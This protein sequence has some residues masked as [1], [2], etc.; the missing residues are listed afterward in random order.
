MTATVALMRLE[1][2]TYTA[3][4]YVH[5]NPS[6]VKD[7]MYSGPAVLGIFFSFHSIHF[8]CFSCVLGSLLS[9]FKSTPLSNNCYFS[10][11]KFKIGR[12]TFRACTS[13]A[14]GA[15]CVMLLCD[16]ILGIYLWDGKK[17]SKTIK[18]GVLC[19]ETETEKKVHFRVKRLYFCVVPTPAAHYEQWIRPCHDRVTGDSVVSPKALPSLSLHVSKGNAALS[20]SSLNLILNIT[21]LYIAAFCQDG[22]KSAPKLLLSVDV[23]KVFIIT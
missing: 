9:F 19:S 13:A 1:R 21:A 7:S 11:L 12:S 5:L 3:L 17:I 20:D 10:G 16:K 15:F 2:P 18:D 23:S 14:S 4:V 8:I 6:P 22:K